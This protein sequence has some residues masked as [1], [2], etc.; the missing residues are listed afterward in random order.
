MGMQLL[1]QKVLVKLP[2]FC[3]HDQQWMKHSLLIWNETSRI[4]SVNSVLKSFKC[5]H[6][7]VSTPKLEAILILRLSQVQINLKLKSFLS[8]QKLM[9]WQILLSSNTKMNTKK[10]QTNQRLFSKN[11]IKL[12]KKNANSKKVCFYVNSN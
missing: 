1:S 2:N 12:K 7:S 10:N 11:L 8:S 4:K 3:K 6:S 5:Q 9:S